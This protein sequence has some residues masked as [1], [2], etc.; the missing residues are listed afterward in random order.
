MSTKI[1][2]IGAGAIGG[3]TAAYM[4]K[5]GHDVTLVTKHPEI[6]AMANGEG[7]S[8]SG[9]RGSE[10]LF[11]LRERPSC[12]EISEIIPRSIS[13]LDSQAKG[14]VAAPARGR[15]LLTA[16]RTGSTR[17]EMSCRMKV[18]YTGMRST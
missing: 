18:P 1:C 10:K 15:L 3:V 6:A 2:V 13:E 5:A 4:A 9:V 16:S 17:V 14:V 7:L 8:I 11:Q 12:R